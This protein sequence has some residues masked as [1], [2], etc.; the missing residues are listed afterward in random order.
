M[1]K[2]FTLPD[3]LTTDEIARAVALYATA[4]PG[5]FAKRCAAEIIEPVLP[6]INAKLGQENN[7]AYLAYG[8]QYVLSTSG[9]PRR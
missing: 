4:K 5:T 3:I 9:M 2:T 8:V 1:T 6:R 7:A